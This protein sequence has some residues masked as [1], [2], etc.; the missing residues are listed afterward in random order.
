[1]KEWVQGQLVGVPRP[2]PAEV[3]FIRPSVRHTELPN[4]SSLGIFALVLPAS[5]QTEDDRD[6]RKSIHPENFEIS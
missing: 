6:E 1:M 5:K 4:E 3:S 2:V